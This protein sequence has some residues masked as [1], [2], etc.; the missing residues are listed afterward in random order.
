MDVR[1]DEPESIRAYLKENMA[2]GYLSRDEG[3]NID[4]FV[5]EYER[6][7]EMER[8]FDEVL[9]DAVGVE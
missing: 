7:L 4:Q 1:L 5:D 3:L 8:S 9:K 2:E 6:L